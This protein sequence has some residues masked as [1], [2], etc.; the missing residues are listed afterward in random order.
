MYISLLSISSFVSVCQCLSL[1]VCLFMCFSPLYSFLFFF[2][3]SF[4]PCHWLSLS[5]PSVKTPQE[6]HS[7]KFFLCPLLCPPLLGQIGFSLFLSFLLGLF[8]LINFRSS[9]FL[10]SA[11]LQSALNKYTFMPTFFFI[12]PWRCIRW[13][14]HVCPS[15]TLKCQQ[16]KFI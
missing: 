4:R 13:E 9:Y 11:N 3:Q 7:V 8:I 6:H 14:S 1:R 5:Q 12:V 15:Q 2:C 10:T 16:R